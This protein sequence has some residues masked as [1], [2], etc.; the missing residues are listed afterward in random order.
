MNLVA[1]SITSCTR[2]VV[3]VPNTY[4]YCTQHIKAEGDSHRYVNGHDLNAS[5]SLLF[6]QEQRCHRYE[7]LIRLFR[8]YRPIISIKHFNTITS[9]TIT[10]SKI[11]NKYHFCPLPTTH[12][13]DNH[14]DHHIAIMMRKVHIYLVL[15]FSSLKFPIATPLA[16][17]YQCSWFIGK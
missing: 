10:S 9:V 2:G 1:N 3:Y 5:T 15:R 16:R 4:T 14:V 12:K 11:K 8:L 7:I 6:S 13:H 17:Q